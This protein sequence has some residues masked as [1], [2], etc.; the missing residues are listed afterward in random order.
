MRAGKCDK[1]NS[2]LNFA[3]VSKKNNR[4]FGLAG[5]H[6]ICLHIDQTWR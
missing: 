3:N 2:F 5:I 4:D 6:R 1:A